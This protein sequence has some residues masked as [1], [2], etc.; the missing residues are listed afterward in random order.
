VLIVNFNCCVLNIIGKEATLAFSYFTSTS[1]VLYLGSIQSSCIT[2]DQ[3]YLTI[4]NSIFVGSRAAFTNYQWNSLLDW[5]VGKLV[6]IILGY[7]GVI[8]LT[9]STPG[10][11]SLIS[12][13]VPLNEDY[14]FIGCILIFRWARW[15]MKMI[16]TRERLSDWT[17]RYN[18]SYRFLVADSKLF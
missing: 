5:S 16:L 13:N 12:F 9:T 10:T 1:Y 6:V 3:K 8:P 2:D 4:K 7:S 14:H 15:P 17:A 18:A 11:I